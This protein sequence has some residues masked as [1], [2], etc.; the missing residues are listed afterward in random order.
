MRYALLAGLLAVLLGRVAAT[1]FVFNDTTDEQSH[2]VAGLEILENRRYEVEEMH[3]PL[4]RL[5]LAVV[6]YYRAGLRREG[7]F[8]WKGGA[9]SR[10]S[11]GFY[12]Y[13]LVL[14]RAGNLIFAAAAFLFVWLW[15][16]RLFGREA[17]LAA[18]FLVACCPNLLA[19]AGVATL[20]MAAAATVLAAAYCLWRWSEVPGWR[21]GLA[22]GVASALAVLTKFSALVFLPPLA[23]SYFLIARWRPQAI[24]AR[25]AGCVLFAAVVVWGAYGFRAGALAPPGHRYVSPYPMGK[26]DSAAQRFARLIEHRTLPAPKFWKGLVDLASHNQTGHPA[27]LLGQFSRTGWWYYFPVVVA[28]KTTLPLLA[29]AGLGFWLGDR[30]KSLYPL[31]GVLVVMGTSLM[32][33][34]NLGVRHILSLYLFAAILVSGLAAAQLTRRVQLAA[35]ALLLW[36]A[37]ESIAAH[38]DYLAYFNQIARGR[39]ERFLAD[40]NL[41]W[42]QDIYRLAQY[43]R[44]SNIADLQAE[45]TGPAEPDKFGLQVRP[46]SGEPGW[47]AVSINHLLELESSSPHVKALWRLTPAARIG[48]TIR[49]YHVPQSDV[50]QSILNP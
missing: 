7:Y 39:E 30:R 38:P 29:L 45:L 40:S 43:V 18:C 8:L 46:L 27:Y 42:G 22:A 3:P 49:L 4:A 15:A 36:H 19:H 17:G 20:D 21:W 48:K 26:E 23:L 16:S 32:A 6:P 50:T 13:T 10:R 24:L 5:V 14:A 34:I 25:S 9:W 47:K 31:M 11:E 2:L 41:D 28:V 44:R 35:A 37:G 1:W 12:W 33:S